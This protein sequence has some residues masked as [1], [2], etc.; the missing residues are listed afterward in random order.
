MLVIAAITVLTAGLAPAIVMGRSSLADISPYH[1]QL[2]LALSR[3]DSLRTIAIGDSHTGL[4]FHPPAGDSVMN[5]AWPD[6]LLDLEHRAEWALAR[7]PRVDTVLIQFQPHMFFPHRER[8]YL[9]P[10]SQSLKSRTGTWHPLSH[11]FPQFDVCCRAALPRWLWNK[12]LGRTIP[13][14]PVVQTNGYLDYRYATTRTLEEQARLEIGSYGQLRFVDSLVS[15]YA[16]FLNRLTASGYTVV[17]TRYPLT[18]EYRA[19]LGNAPFAAAEE[20]QAQLIERFPRLRMC[21]S[22]TWEGSG[23][24]FLNSDHL[25]RS[26]ADAYWTIIEPCTM[27]GSAGG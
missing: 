14:D 13:P 21:G 24:S 18:K 25:K 22:W 10:L 20:L 7:L 23:D 15:R 9:S 4:G 6:A 5:L 16:G 3:S 2:R 1:L 8:A 11:L 17:L 27:R 26:G 19:Q 12:L